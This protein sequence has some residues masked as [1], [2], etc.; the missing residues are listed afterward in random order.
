MNKEDFKNPYEWIIYK[1]KKEVPHKTG[2]KITPTIP[3]NQNNV[4]INNMLPQDKRVWGV[5]F[6]KNNNGRYTAMYN[7]K[8]LCMCSYEDIPKIQQYFD[9]RYK[10]D[11]LDNISKNLKKKYNCSIQKKKRG[12]KPKPYS[13]N[14]LNFQTKPNGRLTVR[15]SDNGKQ[16]SICQCYESERE[17]VLRT[18]NLL[19]KNHDI[20]SIK[21]IMRSKYNIIHRK[22]I[23]TNQ[24]KH[25]INIRDDG[26]VFKDG[27]LM[28][29][30][31]AIYD[32]IN[33]YIEK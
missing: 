8:Y 16:H 23:V 25:E 9:K 27:K 29:V 3:T 10:G 7:K 31:N 15:V 17:E 1:V 33:N 4:L 11:N 20:E 28:T 12:V 30:D 14:N 22:R 6:Y 18:F 2:R 21:K 24:I 26:T 13:E 5:K 32:F 19:K